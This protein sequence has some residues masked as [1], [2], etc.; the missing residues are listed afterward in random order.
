MIPVR[1]AP[2]PEEIVE[3]AANA[4]RRDD[5]RGDNGVG[6]DDFGS[7]QEPHL[8]IV[9]ELHLVHESLLRQRL[10]HQSR[11]LNRRADLR[12]DRGDELLIAGGERLLRRT[13]GEVDDT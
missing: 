4:L 3:V 9:R 5:A 11:V 12:R 1:P 6:R 8:K 13:V 7:R 10:A 2:E